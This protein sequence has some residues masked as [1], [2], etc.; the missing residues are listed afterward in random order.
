MGGCNTR[1]VLDQDAARVC[2]DGRLEAVH[3][4]D[5]AEIGAQRFERDATIVARVP[6]E[7]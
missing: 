1:A 6:G 7:G 4:D 3:A 2:S 5:S